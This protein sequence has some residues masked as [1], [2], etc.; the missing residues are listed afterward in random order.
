MKLVD[1]Y[2]V[3]KSGPNKSGS[4]TTVSTSRFEGQ[5]YGIARAVQ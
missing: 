4:E 2:A 3:S 1:E 5:L